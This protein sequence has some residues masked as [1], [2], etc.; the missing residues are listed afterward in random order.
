M[1]LPCYYYSPSYVT[2]MTRVNVPFTKADL[3][4]HVLRMCP[5]QWQLSLQPARKGDD[6][7]GHAFSSSIS[8]GY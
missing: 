3:V 5:H 8:Q 7:H 6:S 1:Q 2:G 4:S